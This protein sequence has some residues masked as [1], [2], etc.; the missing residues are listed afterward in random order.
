MEKEVIQDSF[1]LTE[2]IIWLHTA[3]ALQRVWELI[4]NITPKLV[5]KVRVHII[6]PAS[7]IN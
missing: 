4:Q 7:P 1:K 2:L 3:D 5:S 6:K